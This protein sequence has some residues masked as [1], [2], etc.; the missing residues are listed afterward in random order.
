MPN[1]ICQSHP[2]N[3]YLEILNDTGILG[4]IIFLAAIILILKNIYIQ[5]KEFNQELIIRSI[6]AL[7]LIVEIF[8]IKSTGSFFTSNNA[9]F[10]FILISF[11]I[12]KR[13][14]I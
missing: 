13:N 8:P 3:Y 5:R 14:K 9:A 12:Q 10:I 1:R 2:H 6:F 11:I 7:I 4:L